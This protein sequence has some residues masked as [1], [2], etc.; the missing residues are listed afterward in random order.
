[1]TLLFRRGSGN[2]R[3]KKISQI[4]RK[5]P[6]QQSPQRKSDPRTPDPLNR[7]IINALGSFVAALHFL[8]IIPF[9]GSFGTSEQE[10]TRSVPFFPL[11]GLF[12]GCIALPM[13]WGLYMVL[14]PAVAAVLVVFLLLSFSGGLHL[15]GLADTADGFFS[16]R[17]RERVLEIMRDSATGAMGVL[18]LILL[19]ALKIACLASMKQQLALAVFLMPLAGRIAILLLMAVL[20]YARPEGGLGTLFQDSF[21]TRQAQLRA[22]AVMLVFSG[23]SWAAAGSQGLL[24]VFAVLFITGIF[25]LFCRQKIGGITGDTL[26]AACELAEATVALVFVLKLGGV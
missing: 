15:D 18:A 13:A 6:E 20:P 7:R 16:A 21:A 3:R 4:Q 14:P 10:L 24:A 26:G 2:R 23:M 17:P 12:F 22:L 19:L 5:E 8:S 9:S 1:M 11:V 25:A